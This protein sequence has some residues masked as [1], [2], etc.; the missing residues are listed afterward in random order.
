MSGLG[1][2]NKTTGGIVIAAVQSQLFYVQTPQDLSNATEHVC[3]LVRQTKRAYPS[4]DLILFLEYSIHGL[5][6]SM[7]PLIMCTLDGPELAAFRKVCKEEKVWGTFSIMEKNEIS[8]SANPWNTGITITSSGEIVHYYRKMYPWIPVEPWY[9][10]NPR[11]FCV[12]GVWRGQDVADYL[13]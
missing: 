1:G 5:F 2:L 3:A 11:D 4:M 8:P 10:G 7:D 9:P 13:P 6:M 12:H